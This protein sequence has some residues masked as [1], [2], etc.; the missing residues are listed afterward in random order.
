MAH[1]A[2]ISGDGL[3]EQVVVISNADITDPS[4]HE[5]EA[6][7][8][9]LCEQIVGPGRWVQTSWSGS[10]RHRFAGES[11]R[12]T[13]DET[14]DAFILPQPYPSWTL[15]L[16]S[17]WDWSAPVPDPSDG[18]DIYYWDE[19]SQQWLIEDLPEIHEAPS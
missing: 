7:G 14:L 13:Y 12:M 10:F 6:T 4:G 18:V 11:P 17:D 2:R 15:D 16:D 9:S 8:R 5:D 3:V 1:F 19:D